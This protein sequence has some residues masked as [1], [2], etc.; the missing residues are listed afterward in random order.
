MLPTAAVMSRPTA[1]SATSPISRRTRSEVRRQ[2]RDGRRRALG[3]AAPAASTSGGLPLPRRAR[4]SAELQAGD[5]EHVADAPQRVD[6]VGLHQVDLAAEVGDVGLDDVAVAVEVVVPHVVEDLGLREHP[7]G[8]HHEVAQQLE[9]RGRQ[10]HRRAA[11]PDLVAVLVELQVAGD[12]AG[13]LGGAL[14]ATQHRA[15]ARHHLLEAEGLGHVVVA[16]DR[17]PHDLVLVGVLGGEE[18]HGHAPVGGP[19]AGGP[20]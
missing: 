13:H 19:A 2:R 1:E 20:R 9:L 14:G 17:E 3:R 15:D 5:P 8:V 12:E 7:P 6:Q 4:R 11:P 16:A 18:D 10:R